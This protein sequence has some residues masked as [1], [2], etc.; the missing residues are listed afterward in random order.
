MWQRN[1]DYMSHINGYGSL[2]SSVTSQPKTIGHFTAYAKQIE[3]EFGHFTAYYIY[4][5]VLIY[6]LCC[7][8]VFFYISRSNKQL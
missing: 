8:F 2:H 4:L 1:D 5:C 3:F 7:E 6:E